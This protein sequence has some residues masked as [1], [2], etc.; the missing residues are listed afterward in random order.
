[1]ES[2][3]LILLPVLLL[4]VV[5]SYHR[6]LA[7]RSVLANSWSN[8]DAELRRRHALVTQLAAAVGEEGGDV[9]EARA[10]GEAAD[11]ERDPAGRRA[12]E[13][14][15]SRALQEL[16]KRA[17]G[18]REIRE[19]PSFVDL[20]TQLILIEDRITG[21]VRFYNANV[22]VYNKRVRGVPSAAVAWLARFSPAPTFSVT[23]VEVPARTAVPIHNGRL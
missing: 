5:A 13:E 2:L 3:V 7:Q 8:V 19:D 21:A 17:E 12:A 15:L 4:F 16:V 10:A 20:E 9:E 18:R 6:F 14:R 1:M 23:P 22:R 11:G